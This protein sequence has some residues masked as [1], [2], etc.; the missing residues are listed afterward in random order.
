MAALF[1]VLVGVFGAC[2]MGA[3]MLATAAR[4]AVK[5]MPPPAPPPPRGDR[6]YTLVDVRERLTRPVAPPAVGDFVKLVFRA[7]VGNVTHVE[8]MWVRVEFQMGV[9]GTARAG[10][11]EIDVEDS[12]YRGRLDSCPVFIPANP[13]DGV[14]FFLS[15]VLEVL[16]GD[17]NA[18]RH[19]H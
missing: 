16:P 4:A 7:E 18:S 2:A 1:W 11:A 8:R 15:N 17:A 9:A 10:T 5:A 13:G 14:V 12:F 6:G 3:V 19:L